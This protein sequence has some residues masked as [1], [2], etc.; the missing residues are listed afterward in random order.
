ME[1]GSS[2]KKLWERLHPSLGV[3]LCH[4]APVFP[5]ILTWFHWRPESGELQAWYWPSG[6]QAG[7]GSLLLVV[8][9]APAHSAHFSYQI[10]SINSTKGFVLLHF[11][12]F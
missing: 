8:A 2:S 6:E 10:L 5:V 11:A 12:S 1:D 7:G 4:L 9:W 3:A